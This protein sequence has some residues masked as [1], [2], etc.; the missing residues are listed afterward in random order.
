[1][2]LL[3]GI[4]TKNK[5]E[6]IMKEYESDFSFSYFEGRLISLLRAIA[7]TNERKDLSIYEGDEDLSFF[8][9]LI[10]MQYRGSLQLLSSKVHDGIIH[11][12]LKVFMDDLHYNKRVKRKDESFIVSVEKDIDANTDPG[13]S[14]C[15]VSCKN[16]GASF[17]ALHRKTC[18]YCHTP[19][20]LIHDDW[21]IT[22]IKRN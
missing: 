16:C 5:L 10:D 8:D 22:S 14:L 21:M 2:P 17:D 20:K 1:M 18:L 7:F 4:K 11:L 9:H 6:E 19:Y 3:K 13:F 15:D 12:K